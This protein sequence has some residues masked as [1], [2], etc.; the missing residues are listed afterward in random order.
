MNLE[1][2]SHIN[3]LEKKEKKEDKLTTSTNMGLVVS[4]FIQTCN[5]KALTPQAPCAKLQNLE[6]KVV[7]LV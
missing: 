4:S 1:K 7:I 6:K 5:L 2:K 3:V